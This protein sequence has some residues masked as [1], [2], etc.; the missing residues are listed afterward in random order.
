MIEEDLIYNKEMKGFKMRIIHRNCTEAH[1]I[2]VNN[3]Y[4]SIELD[5][6][7]E[8]ALVIVDRSF[9]NDLIIIIIDDNDCVGFIAL[10]D[11]CGMK[12]SVHHHHHHAMRLTDGEKETFAG[13]ERPKIDETFISKGRRDMRKRLTFH[14]IDLFE[15]RVTHLSLPFLCIVIRDF[16]SEIRLFRRERRRSSSGF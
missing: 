14:R 3:Q 2:I 7:D 4:F 16:R 15:N 12:Q 11:M 5:F 8:I 9:N 1:L 10:I 13:E 6:P